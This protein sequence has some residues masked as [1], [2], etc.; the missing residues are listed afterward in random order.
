MSPDSCHFTRVA[1]TG[2]GQATV[3]RQAD[4]FD[5]LPQPL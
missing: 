4:K 1:G 3:F 2:S 5:P